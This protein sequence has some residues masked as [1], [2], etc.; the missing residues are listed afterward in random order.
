MPFYESSRAILPNGVSLAQEPLINSYS[1]SQKQKFLSEPIKMGYFLLKKVA[2][3]FT[4]IPL[5]RIPP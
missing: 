1:I 5:P 3:L 2:L 4:Y